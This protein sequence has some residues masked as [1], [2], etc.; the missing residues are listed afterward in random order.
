M[1]LEIGQL[2]VFHHRQL[3]EIKPGGVHM[4]G[5]DIGPLGQR[6]F[7]YY[8]QNQRL[9]ADALVDLRPGSKLHA[10]DIGDEPCGL[11]LADAFCHGFPLGAGGVQIRLVVVAV[12][13]Q[14]QPF[15]HVDEVVAV[16]LLIKQPLAQRVFLFFHCLILLLY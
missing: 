8:R 2:A 9:A 4:G 6:L 7:A 10:P 16:L 13:L 15:I 1:G 5:G 11:R 12:S 3:L 14:Q